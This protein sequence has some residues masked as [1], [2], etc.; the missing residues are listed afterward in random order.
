MSC[1]TSPGR[2]TMATWLVETSAVVAPMRAANCRWASGGILG[3]RRRPGT[4][5][6]ATSMPGRHHLPEGAPVQRL[7]D[8]EH[9]LGLDRVDLGREVVDEVV[10]GDPGKAVLVDVKMRQG[11]T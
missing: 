7:L 4:R 9:D 5:T 1:N 8:R 11:G 10:L 6:A 3:R 2:E